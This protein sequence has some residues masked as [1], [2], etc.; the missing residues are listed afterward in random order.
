MGLGAAQT[1][2]DPLPW[3]ISSPSPPLSLS[4]QLPDCSQAKAAT[5]ERTTARRP[6]ILREDSYIMLLKV[7]Y[8]LLMRRRK[9]NETFR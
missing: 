7:N 9:G 5:P 2:P 3:E 8:H 6:E 1:R 4:L